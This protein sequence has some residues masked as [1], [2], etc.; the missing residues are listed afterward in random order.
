[1]VRRISLRVRAMEGAATNP[2][3]LALLGVCCCL[4]NSFRASASGWAS[5]L[6]LTLLG[7][8]RH[9]ARARSFRSNRV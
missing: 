5:P 2:I 6:S 8:V 3:R 7:P 9:C 4:V 1:M